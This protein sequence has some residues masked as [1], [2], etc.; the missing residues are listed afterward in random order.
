M[1]NSKCLT[2][3]KI[4]IL[5]CFSLQH[6]SYDSENDKKKTLAYVKTESI[7]INLPTLL[8]KLV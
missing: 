1:P 8:L 5:E 4:N 2:I 3:T 7:T 6:R